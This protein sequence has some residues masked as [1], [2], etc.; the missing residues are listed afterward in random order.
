ML[1]VFE[2]R[3]LAG[4]AEAIDKASGGRLTEQPQEGDL[5]G[6]AGRTL[7]LYDLPG[8]AAERV[9]LVGC[10][11]KKEF[12]R[13]NYRKAL[14]AAVAVLQQTMPARPSALA[15]PPPE[16]SGSLPGRARRRD[17]GR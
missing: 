6:E 17:H 7:M 5:D 10:G 1:G 11:K 14:A 8:I 15:E 3:K 16:G 12:T 13:A 9:L 2:K 4:T